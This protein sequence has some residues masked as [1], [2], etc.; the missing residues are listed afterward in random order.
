MKN[1]LIVI[2]VAA[3][4]I[5]GMVWLIKTP[6][7]PG[8]LDAFAQCL[9]DSGAKYYGAFWCPNCKNQEAMFGRSA[10]LLPRI[11]CSTPDGRGQLLICQDA[12]IT[13][14]PTWDFPDGRR[15][16]GVLPL[17]RLAEATACQLS[18]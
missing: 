9:N 15:E 12:G 6:A 8:K 1:K 18:Q 3:L 10:R 4:L 13:G 14:Y 11:E 7:K 5:A 16:T 2:L 17:E